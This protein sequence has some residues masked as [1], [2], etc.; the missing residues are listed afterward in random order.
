[1][2]QDSTPSPGKAQQLVWRVTPVTEQIAGLRVLSAKT[3]PALWTNLFP[4]T[5][6]RPAPQEAL[7]STVLG[8]CVFSLPSSIV[9]SL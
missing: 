9:L 4:G 8:V 5:L 6:W 7:H 2:L 3:G 1:M